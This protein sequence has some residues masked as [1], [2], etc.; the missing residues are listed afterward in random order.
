MKEQQLVLHNKS[1]FPLPTFAFRLSFIRTTDSVLL[2]F[3]SFCHCKTIVLQKHLALT[4]PW[5]TFV[6]IQ[7]QFNINIANNC[8]N[9][10]KHCT[11]TVCIKLW[12]LEVSIDWYITWLHISSSTDTDVFVGEG[13]MGGG[14]TC[15]HTFTALK[16]TLRIKN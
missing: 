9:I 10:E 12:N 15:H 5:V 3:Y 16:F 1:T 4:M 13:C 6:Q 11:L 14:V 2:S 8:A 7:K